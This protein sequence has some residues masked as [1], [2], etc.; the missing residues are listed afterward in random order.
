[1]LR[2]GKSTAATYGTTFLVRWPDHLGGETTH[3]TLEGSMQIVPMMGM[4]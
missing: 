3:I 1:V 4:V 2:E